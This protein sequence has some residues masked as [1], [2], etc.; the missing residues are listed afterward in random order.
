M[1][2]AVG[3]GTGV[4][5][6]SGAGSILV[7]SLKAVGFSQLDCCLYFWEVF[8]VVVVV[9]VV[10]GGGGVSIPR[11]IDQSSLLSLLFLRAFER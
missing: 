1:D 7:C 8:V 6:A 10:V 4:S 2:S 11:E 5:S 3:A 9:V